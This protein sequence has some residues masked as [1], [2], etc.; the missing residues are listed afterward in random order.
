MNK[1]KRFKS[2]LVHHGIK[3]QRWGIRRF[4]N[5]DGSLTSAGKRRYNDGNFNTLDMI[6]V[7]KE[8]KNLSEANK[9]NYREQSKRW[10]KHLADLKMKDYTEFSY[11]YED[12][13][14]AVQKALLK[15]L[16]YSDKKA[17]DGAYWLRK[18]GFDVNRRGDTDLMDK[19][20]K[21][22]TR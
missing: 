5:E 11:A 2:I 3:G 21:E 4:R 10:G 6:R 19:I 1:K 17:D 9:Q 18:N 16:G 15:D 14:R 13:K 12:G 22:N 8:V 20:I 7:R